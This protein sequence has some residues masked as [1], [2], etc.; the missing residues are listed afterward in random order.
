M[1]KKS[2]IR[3]ARRT[4][5]LTLASACLTACI[6]YRLNYV[7]EVQLLPD[8]GAAPAQGAKDDSKADQPIKQAVDSDKSFTYRYGASYSTGLLPLGC[9]ATFVLY[10]G[11]CWLY[12][13]MPFHDDV[14]ANTED[15]K[16][17]LRN[18]LAG[19]RYKI[20][21]NET[22]DVSDWRDGAYFLILD[23]KDRILDSGAAPTHRP[24]KFL[25]EVSRDDRGSLAKP[26]E[27]TSGVPFY[28]YRALTF[29]AYSGTATT[30]ST[31]VDET[32]FEQVIAAG[33]VHYTEYIV[34]MRDLSPNGWSW[35][36]I[37]SYAYRH[38]QIADFAANIPVVA[39]NGSDNVAVVVSDPNTRTSVDLSTY[40]NHY[41]IVSRASALL[42]GL[43]YRRS[44][45]IDTPRKRSFTTL[46]AGAYLGLVEWMD[47]QVSNGSRTATK[48]YFDFLNE[49]RG[50]I[51]FYYN[52]PRWHSAFGFHAE[53][54]HYPRIKLATSIEFRG[55]ARYQADKQVFE[56]QRLFVD[57][58][59][60]TAQA[61]GLS[62]SYIFKEAE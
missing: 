11:A 58:V 35:T 27:K 22:E 41:S 26:L 7:A 14:A 16:V 61:L 31:V 44:V 6:G 36:F 21:S 32:G 42:G 47:N 29:G 49:W 12:L 43:S 20:L 24:A 59:A 1:T 46:D 5:A 4:I 37:P 18:L 38:L 57:H 50:N 33:N 30:K 48:S 10:G 56:R 2:I 19:H 45:G 3:L 15:A 55:P 8:K 39:A 17:N 51:N 23:E 62:Y 40:T 9:A 60:V 54:G 28:T 25:S 52:M 13:M 34:E 53:F